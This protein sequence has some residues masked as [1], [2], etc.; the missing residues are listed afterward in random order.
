MAA[1]EQAEQKQ[2]CKVEGDEGS[3][4]SFTF[5]DGRSVECDLSELSED[6]QGALLSHGLIQKI[7]DSFAG[8][9]GDID[10]ALGS[11]GQVWDNLKEGRWNASRASGGGEPRTTELAQAIA[12]IKG[13][14]LA[15]VQKAVNEATDEKRKAWRKN[16][17]VKARIMEIRAEKAKAKMEKAKSDGESLDIEG[18]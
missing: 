10:A 1:E 8:V 12:D 6:I 9:K 15:T 4:L 16:S 17:A 18:L 2:F 11:A 13:L 14:D 5:K 7:R 3:V